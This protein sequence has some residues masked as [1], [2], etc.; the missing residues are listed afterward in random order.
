[1]P[2]RVERLLRRTA[3]RYYTRRG[4]LLVPLTN[5]VNWPR[6]VEMYDAMRERGHVYVSKASKIPVITT[7]EAVTAILK[8]TRFKSG[9]PNKS[10]DP[11]QA[12]FNADSLVNMDPPRHT[13]IRK[14]LTKGFT[15]KSIEAMAPWIT[16]LCHELLD[17]IEG[18]REFDAVPELAMPVPIH[19]ICKLLDIPTEFVPQLCTWGEDIGPSIDPFMTPRQIRAAR[20]SSVEIIDYFRDLVAERRGQLGD[21]VLSAFIQASED[22]VGLTETE[23]LATCQLILLAGFGTSVGMLG[24]LVRRLT[25]NEGSWQM[26]QERP[27]LIPLAVEET[28]RMDSPVQ[29]TLRYVLEPTEFYGVRIPAGQRTIALIAGANRDPA[30]FPDPHRFDIT[31]E[32]ASRQLAFSPGIHH[33]L[34]SSLARMEGRILLQAMLERLPDLKSAGPAKLWPTLA[35]RSALSVPVSVSPQVLARTESVRAS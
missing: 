20:K 13:Q 2:N 1:M 15:L 25:E 9:P 32:N 34:G 11:T 27:E 14:L 24:N 17:N 12:I 16:E 28:L 18:R 4:D 3:Y 31:R 7:H 26:L 33:C 5:P 23:L 21:D 22:G 29:V 19:V 35:Y 10:N 6:S 8:D 30:V